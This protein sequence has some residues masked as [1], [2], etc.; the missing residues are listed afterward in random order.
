MEEKD[1][2]FSI[3][4]ESWLAPGPKLDTHAFDLEKGDGIG[5]I[6]K[7]RVTRRKKVSGGGI[8]ILYNK[9]KSQINGA[10]KL[11]QGDIRLSVRQEESPETQEN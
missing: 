7:P 10:K 2:A 11:V 3:V 9:S 5:R 6:H 1:A 8:A 4:P